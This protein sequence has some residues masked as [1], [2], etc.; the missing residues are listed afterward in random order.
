MLLFGV[1]MSA[2]V[3]ISNAL[4]AG[5]PRGAR[6]ATA[7]ALGITLVVLAAMITALLLLRV[8]RSAAVVA[9]LRRLSALLAL[10]RVLPS[11]AACLLSRAHRAYAVPLPTAGGRTCLL[12][13]P[14]AQFH[15]VSFCSFLK[16]HPLIAI[17]RWPRT[18]Q[19]RWVRLL[20]D[21]QPVIDATVALLPV[22]CVSLVGDGINVALQS[23][24]RGAGKQKVG[25]EADVARGEWVCAESAEQGSGGGG[26][27]R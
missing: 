21:V 24:L 11:F 19:D 22:F 26:G 27:G 10:S 25:G 6:R 2:S 5:C 23:L 7:T 15:S 13:H 17:R 12:P 9:S 3:K 20:T 1:S 4:G 14:P 18:L 8:R 16:P